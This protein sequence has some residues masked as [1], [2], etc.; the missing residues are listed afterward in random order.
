MSKKKNNSDTIDCLKCANQ[1]GCCRMGAWIDLEEAKK[2]L[3]LGI[4]GDFFH[5][6]IDK[7]FPS[8]FKVGTS[9]EDEPCVFLDP[10]GLCRIHKVDYAFKPV[11]CKEFPYEN[12]KIAP[13]ADVLC[14]EHMSRI[15]KSK[16]GKKK[17]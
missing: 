8:G 5:L 12:G 9:Y 16:A 14:V 11:T 10:D 1:S 17:Q 2:I 3:S 6:E 4:K 15:K 7:D 13:I